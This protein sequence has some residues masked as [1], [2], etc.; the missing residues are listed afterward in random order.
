MSKAALLFLAIVLLGANVALFHF[1]RERGAAPP[2]ETATASLVQVAPSSAA[3]A[4]APAS[5][6]IDAASRTEVATPAS[7]DVPA[8]PSPVP[9]APGS[10]P[11]IDDALT[12]P[13]QGVTA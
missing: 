5:S 13:V 1:G 10:T 2:V 3:R 6:S 8:A 11:A 9:S 7:S 4:A 12:I